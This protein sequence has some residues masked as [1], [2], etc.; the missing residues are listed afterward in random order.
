MT[1]S[2]LLKQIINLKIIIFKQISILINSMKIDHQAKNNKLQD[3]I[4][5]QILNAYNQK[6]GRFKTIK[7]IQKIN[8]SPE[9]GFQQQRV[10]NFWS[11]EGVQ[12]RNNLFIPLK[13]EKYHN[14]LASKLIKSQQSKEQPKN[15]RTRNS[16]PQTL[17]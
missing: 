2:I 15:H 3:L 10:K 13:I 8:L 16:I 12:T 17:T 11:L 14:H 7:S 1:N 5:F 6:W 4:I 9:E